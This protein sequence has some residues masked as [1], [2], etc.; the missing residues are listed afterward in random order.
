MLRRKRSRE[1]LGNR[2]NPIDGSSELQVEDSLEHST[3][4][5]HTL[6]HMVEAASEQIDASMDIW[7]NV[8]KEAKKMHTVQ[9]LATVDQRIQEE[10]GD[11]ANPGKAAQAAKKF[12]DT[13]TKHALITARYISTGGQ[14]IEVPEGEDPADMFR[15]VVD[16]LTH[17]SNKEA[18]KILE[19]TNTPYI[20]TVDGQ[21]FLAGGMI[22]AD[23]Q[24]DAAIELFVEYH[25]NNHGIFSELE[26]RLKCVSDQDERLLELQKMIHSDWHTNSEES[27]FKQYFKWLRDNPAV[28]IDEFAEMTL[29]GSKPNLA[30]IKEYVQFALTYSEEEITTENMKNVI[31]KTYQESGWQELTQF[32]NEFKKFIE[33]RISEYES[34]ISRI[35]GIA[36]TTDIRHPRTLDEVLLS[37]EAIKVDLSSHSERRR[38]RKG[39]KLNEQAP[40]LDLNSEEKPEKE[41]TKLPLSLLRRFQNPES[42]DNAELIE[43]NLDDIVGSLKLNFRDGNG[44]ESDVRKIIQYLQVNPMSPGSKRLQSSNRHC[45]NIDGRRYDLM[46]FKSQHAPGL[47]KIGHK[48][49][50]IVHAIIDNR[51]VIIDALSHEDFDKKY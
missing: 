28:H 26:A 21:S 27:C 11:I 23:K 25:G 14:K 7:R 2:D 13:L 38:K 24:R 8:S 40:E 1:K 18:Q 51:L 15:D 42:G 4:D 6:D 3:D 49:I 50:R 47:G 35:A 31:K 29:E 12:L 20:L 39:K 37:K 34:Q 36:R 9:S 45:I 32:Q 19:R 22:E 16:S 33:S 41:K 30:R 44:L 17:I 48:D 46:R 10:F 43:A 5:L